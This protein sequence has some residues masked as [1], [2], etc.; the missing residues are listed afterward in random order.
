MPRDLTLPLAGDQEG[1]RAQLRG[2]GEGPPR[3]GVTS[4]MS[5]EEGPSLL[6]IP[7]C[8]TAGPPEEEDP[9]LHRPALADATQDLDRRPRNKGARPKTGP[10][11]S[12]Q[13]IAEEEHVLRGGMDF[14]LPLP[15]QPRISEMRAWRALVRTEQGNPGVYVQVDEWQERH[16]G[17]VFV[18]D[19]VTGRIYVMKGNLLERIPEVASRQRREETE[20]STP[21]RGQGRGAST[22]TPE[23]L[24]APIPVAESTRQNPQ[25]PA[26]ETLRVDQE[27][28]SFAGLAE[29]TQIRRSSPQVDA[30]ESRT[31]LPPSQGEEREGRPSTPMNSTGKKSKKEQQVTLLRDH[32]SALRRECDR[33][34]ATLLNQH[35]AKVNAERLRG[36]ALEVLRDATLEEYE[37]LLERELQPTLEYFQQMDEELVERVPLEEEE[38]PNFDYPSNFDWKEGDYMWLL[39]K[40]QQHFTHREIWNAVYGFLGHTQPHR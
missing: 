14:Y 39:F 24:T 5:Q 37:Q 33:L 34:E 26:S 27:G 1:R 12:T 9:S 8:V 35:I 29:V 25:T 3:G 31:D 18:V 23:V 11:F 36:D 13:T 22:R 7:L 20:V 38:E 2:V 40:I 19:E 6:Q 10:R 30:V 32:V 21:F 28:L 17:N 16:G 15:G 4:R